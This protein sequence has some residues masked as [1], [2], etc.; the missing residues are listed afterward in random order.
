MMWD[1]AFVPSV[2]DV[3]GVTVVWSDKKYKRELDAFI[4]NR[5]WYNGK[6]TAELMS[7]GAAVHKIVRIENLSAVRGPILVINQNLLD[8]D[9]RK[10]I[11]VYNGGEI[12]YLGLDDNGKI[13]F[14]GIPGL[15]QKVV[16]LRPDVIDPHNAVWTASLTFMNTD[17]EFVKKT[18]EYINTLCGLP[19][20][21]EDFGACHVNE[22][23]TSA[24]TSRLYIDN[25]N[26][27]YATP[28]IK[29]KRKIK[30][31]KLITKPD[32]YQIQRKDE[33]TFHTRVPGFGM[34]IA[35]IIYH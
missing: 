26:Y 20:I 23:M 25:E 4:K 17:D 9:E 33:Y 13:S 2:Y 5:I 28:W 24:N 29:T 19:T 14:S 30:S 22:I 6:W 11:S 15:V 18:A 31:I 7:R 35:E 16:P 8:D 12:L 1:N 32:C 21:T 10:L 3:C 27:F 34:D